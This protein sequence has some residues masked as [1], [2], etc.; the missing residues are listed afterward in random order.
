LGNPNDGIPLVDLVRQYLSIRKEIDSAIEGVVESGSFIQGSNMKSFENEF[1]EY[2]GVKHAMSVGSGTDALRLAVEAAGIKNNDEVVSVAHTFASTVYAIVQNGGRPVLVDVCKETFTIDPILVAKAIGPKTKALLPVH[3]YGQP[4]DM[5]ELTEIAEKTNL[6]VIEDAAQAHGAVYAGRKAGSIGK[7]GCFSFYPSKNLGAYGDGGMVVTESDELAEK[8]R[9]LR[10]YGQ[11]SKYRH[12]TLGYNSR[13]DELQA[14]ILRV[15]LKHLDQ[16]NSQR[17]DHARSY[18]EKLGG[19]G[20][21]VGTPQEGRNR[22][23][24]YHIYAITVKR[25]DDIRRFLAKNGVSTGVHYPTAL[26]KQPV[27]SVLSLPRPKLPVT[28][29]LADEEV[30]LPMFPELREDEINLVVEAI[31]RFGK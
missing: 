6:I 25:R 16:W 24:V 18:S 11:E 5:A 23:H 14:A 10:E 30:S 22:K 26:H 3:I 27:F 20:S 21:W 8:I 31:G 28:E 15:K 29:L 9:L 17:R 19:L 13:L 7:I 2:L 12:L 4:A 1:A